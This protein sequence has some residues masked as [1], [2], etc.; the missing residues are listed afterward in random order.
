MPDRKASTGSS[1]AH[2]TQSLMI[3]QPYSL[4]A[5]ASINRQD[6]FQVRL[7]CLTLNL[8]PPPNFSASTRP[9]YAPVFGSRSEAT[10]TR[11]SLGDEN[12]ER[13]E[14]TAS[15]AAVFLPGLPSVNVV[16]PDFL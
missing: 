2:V 14:R 16:H 10:K 5:L 13:T 4:P 11:R 3:S 8:R 9:S 1:S 6:R 12:A 15:A 7:Q